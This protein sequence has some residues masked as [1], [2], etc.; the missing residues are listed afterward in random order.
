MGHSAID[1]AVGLGREAGARKVLLFHHDPPRT[2]DEL[3]AIVES[4]RGAPVDVEA[5]TEGAVISL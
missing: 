1:Y 3:D 2:D 4:L 5:G